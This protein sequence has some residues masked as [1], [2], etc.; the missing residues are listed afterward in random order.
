MVTETMIQEVAGND[1]QTDIGGTIIC[2]HGQ[3][4]DPDQ[5]NCHDDCGCISPLVKK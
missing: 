2:P 1:W 3:R 4:I 5:R